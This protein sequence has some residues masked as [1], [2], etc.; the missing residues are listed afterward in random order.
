MTILALDGVT[1]GYG[2]TT[3]LRDVSLSVGTGQIVAVLG[4]NGAGKSTLLRTAA[5]TVVP[6][7]GRVRLDG[8]DATRHPPYRRAR[9]GLCLIPEG[10]GIFRG[11]TVEENLR[12]QIPRGASL[13]EAVERAVAVFPALRERLKTT[14]GTLSGGQQQMVALARACV[15]DPKVL[16]I[17]EVSMGLAPIVVD[18]IFAALRGIAATGVAMVLVEQYVGRALEFADT[19]VPAAQGTRVVRGAVRGTGRT[20]RAP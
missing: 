13:G 1:A 11:L 5:G 8:A 4:A 2:T 17:D 16:L 9:R 18:E 20:G 12:L 14:A 6:S 3:V 19:A 15:T 10:R 7:A